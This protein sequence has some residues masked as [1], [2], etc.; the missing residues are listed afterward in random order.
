VKN[1]G[2][3]SAATARAKALSAEFGVSAGLL[4]RLFFAYDGIVDHDSAEGSVWRLT[5]HS[6]M[7]R[8]VREPG[9]RAAEQTEMPLAAPVAE[10]HR[11]TAPS[12]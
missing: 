3:K 2:R 12:R 6:F 8:D 9:A 10:V 7:D 4:D 5:D 11:L 1:G